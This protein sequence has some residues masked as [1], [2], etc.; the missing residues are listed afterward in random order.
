M[1]LFWSS[2]VVRRR[3]KRLSFFLIFKSIESKEDRRPDCTKRFVCL[4]PVC[5]QHKIF[6]DKK[7]QRWAGGSFSFTAATELFILWTYAEVGLSLQSLVPFCLKRKNLTMLSRFN[8]SKKQT[9]TLSEELIRS[10]SPSPATTVPIHRAGSSNNVKAVAASP[11]SGNFS[12][13]SLDHNEPSTFEEM[14]D[15]PSNSRRTPMRSRSLSEESVLDSDDELIPGVKARKS[16]SKR[17]RPPYPFL[18]FCPKKISGKK[19]VMGTMASIFGLIIFDG[20]F[21]APEDRIF[22]P[23]FSDKFLLWVQSHPSLGL[24]AIM[25]VIAGAVVSMVPIGTPL[26]FGCGYI[27]R[28]VYGWRLGLFVATVV[29]MAGSCLGAVICFLLGRYL[30][31]EQVRKWVSKYPLF[32]AI[33]VGE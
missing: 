12:A 4:S 23:D 31:R 5:F 1:S 6:G 2:F 33:D 8:R 13:N 24:G 9:A 30:M 21:R 7:E 29:S 3:R 14:P 18:K 20:F 26:T 22:K 25:V 17:S 11:Y 19:I 15:E 10:S 32:D 27:Y 16:V 28:G